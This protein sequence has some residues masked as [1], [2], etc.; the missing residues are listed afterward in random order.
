MKVFRNAKKVEV[1]DA[2]TGEK[3]VKKLGKV[4]KVAI[5]GGATVIIVGGVILFKVLTEKKNPV[6]AVTETVEE[7]KEAVEDIVT[8]T[9]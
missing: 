2:E 6:E 9:F 5:I 3:I 4:A 8:G 7:T 1:V